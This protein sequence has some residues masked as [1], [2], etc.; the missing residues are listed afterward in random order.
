VAIDLL[1]V[2]GQGKDD[3][4]DKFSSDLIMKSSSTTFTF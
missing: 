4:R 3:I 1:T 2:F